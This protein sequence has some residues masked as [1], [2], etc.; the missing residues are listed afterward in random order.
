MPSA[1]KTQRKLSPASQLLSVADVAER[2][3]VCGET[4]RRMIVSGSLP[5]L[6]VSLG[7]KKPRWRVR[8]RDL[9][10]WIR[11]R[12]VAARGRS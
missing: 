3:S 11:A 4:V 9:D 1:K 8:Q 7:G 2:L 10:S 6:D 5:G 12:T